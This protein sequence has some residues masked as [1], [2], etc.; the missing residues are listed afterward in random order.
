MAKIL[1]VEDDDAIR[2][3][4]ADE[5]ELEGYSVEAVG[6]AEAAI[7]VLAI[8][9]FDLVIVDWELPKMSGLELCGSMRRSG[10]RCGILFLT[11][12]F[13]TRDKTSGLDAGADDYLTKPFEAEELLARVRAI[14]RRGKTNRSDEIQVGD[15][16]FN[17]VT[18]SISR[19]GNAI[20]LKAKEQQLVEFLVRH[21]GCLFSLD[22]LIRNVW[23]SEE[24]VSYDA[25][26]QC[27]KRVREKLDTPGKPSAI[28]TVKGIGY[29]IE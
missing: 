21:R 16:V 9:D 20:V 27:V 26:R 10:K 22:D 12:R 29:I 5:L 24:L 11:G 8:S 23:S 2:A 1:I 4:V 25:V 15:I 19:D 6:S 13:A 7:E 3:N 28:N 14:L 18:R 17:L